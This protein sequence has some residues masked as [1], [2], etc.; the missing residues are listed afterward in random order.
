MNTE[1]GI[2]SSG[3][4]RRKFLYTVGGAALSAGLIGSVIGCSKKKNIVRLKS[5]LSTIGCTEPTALADKLGYYKDEGIEVEFINVVSLVDSLLSSSVDF[6]AWGT[7]SF[8][9]A[10][11]KGLPVRWVAGLHQGGH[12]VITHKDSGIN[13]F[14]DLLGKRIAVYPTGAG[15]ADIS[16]KLTLLDR[17]Y[18]P[19]KDVTLV[20]VDPAMIALAVRQRTVDAGCVCPHGPQM[21][22]VQGWGKPVLSDWEGTL[23]PGRGLQCGGLVFLEKFAK[24][25]PEAAAG[26]KR[27][28]LRAIDF[29]NQSPQEAAKIMADDMTHGSGAHAGHDD[30]GHQDMVPVMELVL[31]HAKYTPMTDVKTVQAYAD[32][33]FKTGMVKSQVDMEKEIPKEYRG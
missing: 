28:Y 4:T 2:D 15:P 17:G 1:R 3:M 22:I 25:T 8:V 11:S 27:A 14:K 16:F 18:D 19:N 31:K 20:P 21:A 7:P 23:F 33:M 6:T 10:V 5:P 9:V 30:G 24:E 12:A 13:G 29:I 32:L 26:V